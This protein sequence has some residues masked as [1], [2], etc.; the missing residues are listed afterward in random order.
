MCKLVYLNLKPP[1]NHTFTVVK[2]KLVPLFKDDNDNG[3]WGQTSATV[4]WCEENYVIFSFIAEFCKFSIIIVI[5][6]LTTVS[7]E[8]KHQN[9]SEEVKILKWIISYI[10]K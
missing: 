4:D 5:V 10:L 6:V 8:K 9:Y 7:N 3:L 2:M 1:S